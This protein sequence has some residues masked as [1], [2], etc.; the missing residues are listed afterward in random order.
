[1][2]NKIK[3]K[4]T[5]THQSASDSSTPSFKH[6]KS[7]FEQIKCKLIVSKK[8]YVIYILFY[9]KKAR[10]IYNIIKYTNKKKMKMLHF[11]A[12]F[13]LV[14]HAGQVLYKHLSNHFL[15]QVLWNI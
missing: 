5:K 15:R 8:A 13:H 7:K 2:K 12:S 4:F 6:I 1:M 10:F 14:A 9:H 11:L 3:K